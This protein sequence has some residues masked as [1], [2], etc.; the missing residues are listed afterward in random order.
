MKLT[1]IVR[2]DL[3]PGQQAVQA[4]HAQR[5]FVAE[6]TEVERE[7]FEKSNTLVLLAVAD[8]PALHRVLRLA[9]ERGIRVSVFREPDLGDAVTALTLEPGDAARRLCRGFPPALQH[10]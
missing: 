10:P 9:G 5:A 4:M 1:T 3:R 7:W 6:H 2:A 8:E